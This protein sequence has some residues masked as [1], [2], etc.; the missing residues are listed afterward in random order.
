M[1]WALGLGFLV[2]GDVPGP[3]LVSGSV[4]VAASGLFILYRETI[5]RTPATALAARDG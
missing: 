3:A 5:R 2:W 1:I 4:I